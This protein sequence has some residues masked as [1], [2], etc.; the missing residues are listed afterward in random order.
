MRI[1][2]ADTPAAVVGSSHGW[3]QTHTGR[4]N[5]CH[6]YGGAV[7][8]TNLNVKADD[9]SHGKAAVVDLSS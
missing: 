9:A 5:V 8:R 1:V 2:F 6:K 4:D 3:L 7:Q